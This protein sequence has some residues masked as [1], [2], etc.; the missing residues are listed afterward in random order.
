[1][2]SESYA[3]MV[4]AGFARRKSYGEF[5]LCG[6]PNQAT[7]FSRLSDAKKFVDRVV[8]DIELCKKPY[9][10]DSVRVVK[11]MFEWTISEVK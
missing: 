5:T 7:L 4:K 11:V 8:Y 10:V 2:T 1:M 3:V 6:N 9:D